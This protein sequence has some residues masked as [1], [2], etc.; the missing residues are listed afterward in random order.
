MDE[1]T[2]KAS[3]GRIEAQLSELLIWAHARMNAQALEHEFTDLIF[4][5]RQLISIMQG[6]RDD[7]VLMRADLR[8]LSALLEQTLRARVEDDERGIAWSGEER[9]N[10]IADRRRE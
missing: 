1:P 2:M 8:R 4:Q 3:L 5:T 10:S 7:L 9:R 6:T